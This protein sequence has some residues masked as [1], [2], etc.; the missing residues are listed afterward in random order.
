LIRAVL[1][2][3]KV[4]GEST[5]MNDEP[6]IRAHNSDGGLAARVIKGELSLHELDRYLPAAEAVIVRQRVVESIT[7]SSLHRLASVLDTDAALTS[8]SENVIGAV[9]VPVGVVGPLLLRGTY[10][11]GSFYVPMATTERALVASTAR[12][13][14][15]ITQ[16]GGAVTIVTR[17]GMSR[18]PLFRCQSASNAQQLADW[19]ASNMPQLRSI[20]SGP[21]NYTNL[22]EIK[23]FIAGNNIWL[24]CEFT[25]GDAM[26]MN[27]ATLA[28]ERIANHIVSLF[29]SIDYLALSGNL[30]T[31]KKD[32]AINNLLGRG[33]S[34]IAEAVINM[35][36]LKEVLHTS[37]SAIC[38]LN[39]RKN[40]LGSA[41]A[42]SSKFNA[43][44]ANIVA[45]VFLATGQDIAEVVESSS[46]YTWAEQRE[47]DLYIS[48]TLPCLEVGT[49]G[50]GTQLAAQSEALNLMGLAGPGDPVG[51]NARQFAE[52]I[53]AAVLAGELGLLAAISTKHLGSSTNGF[54]RT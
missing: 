20:A 51:D 32:A 34:T 12:G 19:V 24:R 10:A 6:Y 54:N 11:S 22:T 13:A 36:V 49:T 2:V 52:V 46:G 50:G 33:K 43:H 14:K 39:T 4:S 15:A 26:G 45:A 3:E 23:S 16:S 35:T 38:D 40:L 17:E 47:K 9:A 41:M 1:V 30:C 7:S 37:A 42:G 31:D 21:S 48:V 29:P 27:M 28:A 18:A 53:S 25:T 8:R 44:F 5:K